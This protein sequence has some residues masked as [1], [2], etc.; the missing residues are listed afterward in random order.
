MQEPAPRRQG[1]LWQFRSGL[2]RTEFNFRGD[3]V[4]HVAR[5]IAAKIE[6][7]TSEPCASS[8][9]ASRR[10]NG[11]VGSMSSLADAV[12][13]FPAPGIAALATSPGRT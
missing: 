11:N 12:D 6:F 5:R 8:V 2:R 1:E 9:Y 3:V 4:F 7:C 13:R 10:R